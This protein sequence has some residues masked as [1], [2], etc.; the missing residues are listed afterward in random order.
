MDEHSKMKQPRT[1]HNHIGPE[2]FHDSHWPIESICMTCWPAHSDADCR[3][4][5]FAQSP[6]VAAQRTE[7]PAQ[8]PFL[9]LAEAQWSDCPLPML[10]RAPGLGIRDSGSKHQLQ[11][12]QVSEGR[13]TPM[14]LGKQGHLRKHWRK[15]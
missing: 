11:T 4:W 12:I 7:A 8:W 6:Q 10:A 14:G 13:G 3:C 5:L 2:I 9:A 1:R 15:Q